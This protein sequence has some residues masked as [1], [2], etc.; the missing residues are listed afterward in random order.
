MPDLVEAVREAHLALTE[1]ADQTP[2]PELLDDLECHVIAMGEVVIPS[3]IHALL[4]GPE[5]AAAQ[6]ELLDQLQ[7]DVSRVRGGDDEDAVRMLVRH[8]RELATTWDEEILP[9]LGESIP[10]ETREELGDA[11]ERARED[12]RSLRA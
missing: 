7:E 10:I 3:A 5:V 11:Y 2:G 4:D 1:F 9:A 6:S 8:L 12:S